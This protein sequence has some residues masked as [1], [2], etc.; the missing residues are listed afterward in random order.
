MIHLA[1][2]AP[3]TVTQKSPLA[4]FRPEAW[5]RRAVV[6]VQA[7]LVIALAYA[8]AD[9]T[10]ALW[11]GR[12]LPL[13]TTPAPTP[14]R[15]EDGQATPPLAED[16]Y[17]AIPAW[18][19]FGQKEAS[20]SVEAPPTPVPVTQLNLRLVGVFFMDRNDR[21]ALA[22]I[23]E[24]NALERGYRIGAA[25]PGNA[26]LQRIQRDHVVV[27]R[28]GREEVLKLPKLSEAGAKTAP[29]TE[30]P[31]PRPPIPPLETPPAAPDAAAEPTTSM[32]PALID[33]S[34]MAQRL[35]AEVVK[36]PAALE[37]I[38]FA[39]PYIQNGQFLGFRLQPGRDRQLFQQ[40]GLNGGD[41]LTEVNGNRLHHPAQGLTMLTE[42]LN[43]DRIAVRVLRNGAEIPLTFSLNGSA[44]EP[45]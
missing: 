25:L 8:L 34:A 19:L 20:R 21:R 7:L 6:A 14:T 12:A 30:M 28:G 40:L 33:A 36:R 23:A 24:G 18:H 11:P 44:T 15:A 29:P 17:A 9:L 5:L 27:S 38:A 35:R 13:L 45:N 41:V 3:L 42:L 39:S 10:L 26:R 43:A 32:E 37:D 22:L 4:L 2:R 16:P 31:A 1:Q